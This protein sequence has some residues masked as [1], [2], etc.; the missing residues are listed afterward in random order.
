MVSHAR[1]YTY[2][3]PTTHPRIGLTKDPELARALRMTTTLLSPDDVRSEAGHVRRLALI[4]A[5]VLA[6]GE[7]QVRDRERLLAL[8]RAR[9]AEASFGALAEQL[10]EQPVDRRGELSRGLDWVRGER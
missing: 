3:V 2:A 10:L 9:A 6:G 1:C 4:G 5:R 8:T 7:A